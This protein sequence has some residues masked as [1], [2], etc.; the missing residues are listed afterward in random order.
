M[1]DNI[2]TTLS[3]QSINAVKTS[4]ADISTVDTAIGLKD[5]FGPLVGSKVYPLVL[6]ADVVLPAMIYQQVNRRHIE[7]DGEKLGRIDTYVL[8][9]RASTFKDLQ[10]LCAQIVDTVAG[11]AGQYEI[12]DFAVDYE[13]DE[14]QYRGHLELEVTTLATVS[15][16][17]P[18]ALVYEFASQAQESQYDNVVRQAVTDVFS[19]VL[20]CDQ[21]QLETVRNQASTAL[22]GL[23]PNPQSHPIQYLSG[24]RLAQT[25][26]LV[27][28]REQFSFIRYI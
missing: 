27:Y 1:I 5:I 3:G 6:P 14:K 15:Q 24:K 20:V 7:V 4:D 22:V 23:Q 25:G 13:P 17:I 2:I 12:T 28:W 10:G 9:V 16:S 8:S 21:D 19:V 26:Q 11:L 18:A